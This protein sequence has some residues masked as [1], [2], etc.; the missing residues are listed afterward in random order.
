MWKYS[1]IIG[2]DSGEGLTIVVIL[3]MDGG[4]INLE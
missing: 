3:Y 2:E 1:N 4:T